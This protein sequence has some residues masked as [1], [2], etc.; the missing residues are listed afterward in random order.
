MNTDQNHKITLKDYQ[1]MQEG[2]RAE[3]FDGK[4]VMELP[5][6][7]YNHQ[8]ISAKLIGE[9]YFLITNKKIN[10]EIIAAPMD[11]YLKE[12]LLV[13]PDLIFIKSE[14]LGIIKDHVHGVPD[15]LIEILS[16]ASMSHDKIIKYKWYEEAGVEEYF[17][18]NPDDKL[19]TCYRLKD[20]KYIEA[21][22]GV[23]ILKSKVMNAEINF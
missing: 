10:G 16:Q 18:I 5:S 3:F 23:G 7:K 21:Y 17:I 13:E 20:Q 14:N 15:M 4:M 8:N 9:I 22:R 6:P 12:D 19:I 11:V 1:E 2:F